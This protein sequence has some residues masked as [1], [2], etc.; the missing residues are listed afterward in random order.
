MNDEEAVVLTRYVRA[1]CPG[2][3]FDE[4]TADAWYDVLADY[5]L[6]A[7]RQAAARVAARQ[8][9]V[10]P[11]EIITEIRK[12]RADRATDLQGPGQPAEIP[13][14]DP[15]DVPAYLA[16]LRNQRARA[17]DGHQLHARPIGQLVKALG[18]GT[19]IPNDPGDE[20]E[21]PRH[22]PLGIS[23]PT[24]RAP[25]GRPCRIDLNGRRRELRT[26]HAA[27]T[28]VAAGGPAALDTPDQ[29]EARRRA[30]AAALARLNGAPDA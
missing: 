5:P 19:R 13:D 12:Q 24:C 7:A 9:F 14:A 11:A 28:R 21:T 27:R 8:P 23:C 18:E 10:S 22:G 2:Q 26:P 30:S 20:P 17:A 4:Y 6:A 3:R 29:I 15:D 16:A 25:L 1:L